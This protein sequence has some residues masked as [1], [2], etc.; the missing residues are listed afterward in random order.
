M[1]ARLP[2]FTKAN[3]KTRKGEALGCDTLVLHLAPA[4]LSGFNVCPNATPG[5]RAACLN[6][7][8]RGFMAPIQ[9][10]RVRRTRE[11]FADPNA[12]LARLDHEITLGE[13]RA[14]RRGRRLAVRLNGTSDLPFERI[15]YRGTWSLLEQHP[16]V[17]FYDYTKNAARM[18][19][20]L[21]GLMP[22]NYHLTFSRSESNDAACY[23]I[24]AHGGNVAM[25]GNAAAWVRR[26][27]V[28]GDAHDLTFLH[29]SGSVIALSPKG[30]ARRDTS[31]F[32][33]R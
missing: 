10:A 19:A 31:G 4:S 26:P 11:F 20:F 28:N 24:L 2:L 6:T 30:R 33:V 17:T 5:C 27:A 8:G 14:A 32:V 29:P 22:P 15:R 16:N 25:V 3:P 1:R 7:A 23:R 9:A 12:F 13:R 21:D 18:A